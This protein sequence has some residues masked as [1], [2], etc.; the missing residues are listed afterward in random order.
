MQSLVRDL[1]LWFWRLAPANPILVR[2]VYGGGR[3]IQHFYI[4]VAYLSILAFIVMIGVVILQSGTSSLADLAKN[5]TQVFNIVS[6]VQLGMVCVLAP[7]FT[8]A[9]ITQEKDSQTFNILLSTPLTN[10]QIVFGSLLSRLYFVFML[11]VAGIPLFCIM[12]VYGGVTGEEIVLSISLAASTALLTGSMAIAISVI[13]I[14][15][16]RTIFTFY[17]AIALYLIVVY[18]LG[19]LSGLTPP[20]SPAAPNTGDRMSWLAAFHPF[21][22]LYVVLGQTPAP[23]EGAVAHYGFPWRYFLAYPHYSYITLTCLV[24]LLLIVLSLFFVRRGAK[25]G[26]QTLGTRL[27]GWLRLS[28]RRG[29]QTRA[30]RHVYNNPISWR[31]S[32]TGA[33]AGGGAMARYSVLTIGLAIAVT[34][35]ILYGSGSITAAE[36]RDWLFTVCAI[37]LGIAL[38]IATTTAATSMTREKESNTLELILCTPL[39]S[40][41]ILRGKIMGLVVAAGPMLLVPYLS[42]LL[43]VIFTSMGKDGTVIPWESLLSMPILLITFVAAACMIGLQASIKSRKT[44][45]AVFSSMGIVIL[46]VIMSTSCVWAVRSGDN[47]ALA[48][49]TWPMTPLTA[50]WTVIDPARALVDRG[51]A[52][53]ADTLRQCR[54]IAFI[55][56]VCSAAIY[57]LI[58]IGLLRSMVRNFDMIIRKQSA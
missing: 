32:V 30:P 36:L 16:G 11:L 48:A 15:T 51:V 38:F 8:A 49:A 7:L 23:L 43:V 27:F 4:R 20:E 39:T 55:A 9:A 53:P 54:V 28:R 31:E 47:P 26:E 3:R 5:A 57:G 34:L 29:E 45:A 44:L 10:A 14:G 25:E 2:V 33:A 1:G 24:S 12:M 56:A 40:R 19:T 37:E 13:K 52:V 22:A 35:L 46:A 58:G 21:L 18:A 6:Q 42:V 41:Q 50:L 17:L